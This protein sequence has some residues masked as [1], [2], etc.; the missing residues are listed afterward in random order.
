VTDPDLPPLDG[1]IRALVRRVA[2]VEPA[3]GGARA[4]VLDRV[5]RVVGLP[6]GPGGGGGSGGPP[7]V[8]DSSAS[9]AP[10]RLAQRLLP[11]AASFALGGGVTAIALH[12]APAAPMLAEPP[13]IVYVERPAAA[14]PIVEPPAQK[15]P[16]ASPSLLAIAPASP[17]ARASASAP[18]PPSPSRDQLTAERQLLDVA[19][20]ALERE[21]P[22]AALEAT[23]THERTFPKGALVQERE[24]MAIRALVLLGRTDEARARADDFRSRFPQ[25]LL[26]PTVE[27]TVGSAHWP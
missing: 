16:G 4:R 3:P 1:D 22:E 12:R 8:P 15:D 9:R 19:R 7:G 27:S 11:L 20:G 25:S 5:E 13:R 14:V 21:E 17:P 23:T 18:A 6:G 26:L 24:A 2:N 10:T